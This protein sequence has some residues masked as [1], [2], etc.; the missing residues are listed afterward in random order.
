VDDLHARFFHLS[1]SAPSGL[2]PQTM[3]LRKRWLRGMMILV[4]VF[5]LAF[6]LSALWLSH[7]AARTSVQNADSEAMQV[8][9]AH[10]A[11]LHRGDFQ[12]AYALFSSRLRRE[13]PFDEFHDV[14]LAHL[15]LLDGRESVFPETTTA[16]RVVVDIHF[17][18]SENMFLTAEFT[19]VRNGGRWWI[20]NIQ[21]NIERMRPQHV[22]RA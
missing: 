18:G 3:E 4:G 19:L 8:V 20:D 17:I 9:K 10:F 7:L 6:G 14:M 5:C 2:D 22:I 15:P 21:W 13:M 1:E 12:A 11:A 16:R